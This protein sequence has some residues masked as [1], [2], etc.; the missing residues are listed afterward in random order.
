[1]DQLENKNDSKKQDINTKKSEDQNIDIDLENLFGNN[2]ND[3]DVLEAEGNMQIQHQH[4]T[5]MCNKYHQNTE[6]AMVVNRLASI[7][8]EIEKNMCLK[9]IS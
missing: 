7:I 4:S 3:D 5:V 8:V 6:G 9:M 1:L 2:N